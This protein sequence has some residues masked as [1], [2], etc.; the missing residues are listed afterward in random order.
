MACVGIVGGLGVGATV[1]YYEKIAAA[2]KVRGVVPDLVITHA[3]VDHGQSLVRAG[4]LDALADYLAGFIERMSRAGA[5]AAAMPAVT[6][7]IC[8]AQLLK[9]T[10]VPLL[11]IVDPIAQELQ[12]R[13]CLAENLD[14]PDKRRIGRP[15]RRCR[16][17]IA[18]ARLGLII[19][20]RAR[21]LLGQREIPFVAVGEKAALQDGRFGC[22]QRMGLQPH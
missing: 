12:A 8:I 5:E 14:S 22:H 20:H 21:E 3:D 19:R 2:C 10:R 13:R 1:H 15:I 11:N 9:R 7:H 16:Q 6:P 18:P 17:K 4:R